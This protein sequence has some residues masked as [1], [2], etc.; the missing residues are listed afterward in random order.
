MNF[1]KF[2]IAQLVATLY[3]V[4]AGIVAGLIYDAFRVVRHLL[5]QKRLVNR[6]V[7]STIVVI[8]DALFWV[9]AA[10]L[11]IAI[12]MSV[13]EGQFRFYIFGGCIAGFLMYLCTVSGFFQKTLAT[14]IVWLAKLMR[15]LLKL[16]IRPISILINLVL[17]PIKYVFL[18]VK[19]IFRRVKQC[20][21]LWWMRSFFVSRIRSYRAI[22][23][24][25]REERLSRKIVTKDEARRRNFTV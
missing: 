7:W 4:F 9:I 21:V 23:R 15:S 18:L 2:A 10:V 1:E 16:I 24:K 3:S 13:G 5:A 22:R 20:V 11:I 19:K 14:L 25:R 6:F 17:L 12:T 8:Q